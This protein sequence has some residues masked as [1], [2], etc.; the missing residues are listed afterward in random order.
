LVLTTIG[1]AEL[2]IELQNSKINEGF[3]HW[4]KGTPRF[5][6]TGVLSALD[7]QRKPSSWFWVGIMPEWDTNVSLSLFTIKPIFFEVSRDEDATARLRP[8]W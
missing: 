4:G 6:L 1:R 3:S 5:F 2:W 8:W 7:S